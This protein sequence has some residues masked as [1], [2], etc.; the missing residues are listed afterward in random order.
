MKERCLYSWTSYLHTCCEHPL[1]WKMKEDVEIINFV[2]LLLWY[3]NCYPK[4]KKCV[5]RWLCGFTRFDNDEDD[6]FA[7]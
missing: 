2:V 4:Y 6:M 7:G 5:L 3:R 1:K